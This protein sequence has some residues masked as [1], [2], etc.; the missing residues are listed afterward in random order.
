DLCR[1]AIA[2]REPELRALVTLDES[3]AIPESGP[4][5]GIAVGVKDIIDSAGLPTRMGSPI[6]DGWRPRG[7]VPD[8]VQANFRDG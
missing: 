2:A 3:P 4:L 6:Y 1:A 5:A 8:G 7:D